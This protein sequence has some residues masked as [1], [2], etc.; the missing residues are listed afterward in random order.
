MKNSPLCGATWTMIVQEAS[1]STS[2]A[3]EMK[4]KQIKFGV[5]YRTVTIIY[6]TQL[7]RFLQFK[8]DSF[9]LAQ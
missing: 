8:E 3:I 5:N 6:G 1:S 2:S 9:N 7:I 4:P